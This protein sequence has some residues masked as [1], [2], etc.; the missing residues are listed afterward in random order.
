M[1]TQQQNKDCSWSEAK[2]LP[3]YPSIWERIYHFLGGH[4]WTYVEPK[5]C[6][7]CKKKKGK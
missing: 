1:S 4:I 7:M 3:Y 2:P 6:V 5:T